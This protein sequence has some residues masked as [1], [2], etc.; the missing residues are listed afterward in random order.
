ML[1]RIECG[2]GHWVMGRASV[3]GLAGSNLGLTLAPLL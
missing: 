3:G 1:L 2:L